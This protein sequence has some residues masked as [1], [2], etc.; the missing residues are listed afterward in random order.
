MIT[1][2][3]EQIAAV[4]FETMRHIE[5]V[6]N[7]LNLVIIEL[8][9]R[10]EKHDQSKL[11]DPEAKEFA[12]HTAK[13]ENLTYGTQEYED[14]R[15]LLEPALKHH[16]AHN[17]HHPEHHRNGINDM[18]FIDIIEMLCDWKASSERHNDGNLKHSI[19]INSKRF[20]IDSQLATILRNSIDAIAD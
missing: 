3:E 2:S 15:K 13:L 11:V 7:I 1:L 9:S 5:R 14:S 4:N 20:G 17:R 19:D 12:I 6:R 18:N 8:L 10:A 16:Y